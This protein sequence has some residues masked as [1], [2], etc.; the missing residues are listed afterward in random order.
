MCLSC[1]CV[2]WAPCVSPVSHNV[3]RTNSITILRRWINFIFGMYSFD[4]I[5]SWYCE[6][7]WCL[8]LY[9][10]G[11]RTSLQDWGWRFLEDSLYSRLAATLRPWLPSFR[12]RQGSGEAWGRNLLACRLA[13]NG[14][15]K[16]GRGCFKLK[17]L[18]H[19]HFQNIHTQM[20]SW[21]LNEGKS[22]DI[23]DVACWHQ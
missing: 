10:Q 6:L 17:A 14:W 23:G 7:L 1:D 21:I 5:K 18:R 20:S 22:N 16:Q 19:W 8:L 3:I 11:S 4:N 2:W 9:L 13:S 15:G 12:L